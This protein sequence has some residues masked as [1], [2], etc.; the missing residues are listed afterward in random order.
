VAAG[1]ARPGGGAVAAGGA[2]PDHPSAP[3]ADDPP[4]DRSTP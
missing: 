3:T 2:L 4:T 1:P